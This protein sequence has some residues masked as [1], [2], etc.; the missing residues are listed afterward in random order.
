MYFFGNRTPGA[1]A[2]MCAI[3]LD[4]RLG[5]RAP[6]NESTLAIRQTVISH[7]SVVSLRGT[8]HTHINFTVQT[9]PMALRDI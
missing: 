8:L 2:V 1:D 6:W 3:V 7:V 5:G 4:L 9:K